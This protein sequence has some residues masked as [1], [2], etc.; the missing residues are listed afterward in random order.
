M[1]DGVYISPS[2][3]LRG[4][5]MCV[6]LYVFYGCIVVSLSLVGCLFAKFTLLS[7]KG[8]IDSFCIYFKT[9]SNIFCS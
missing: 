5:V 9:I 8:K 6:S 7:I 3:I 2:C 1:L 4:G